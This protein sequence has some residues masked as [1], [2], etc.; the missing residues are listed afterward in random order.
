[1]AIELEKIDVEQYDQSRAQMLNLVKRIW[2]P[3]VTKAG[4]L[5]KTSINM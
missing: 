1:M 5:K 4:S 2:L 3:T